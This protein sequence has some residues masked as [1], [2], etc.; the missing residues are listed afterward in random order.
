MFEGSRH[1]LWLEGM[2]YLIE[3]HLTKSWL[4]V[5]EHQ[6]F[7]L[8]GSAFSIK[9]IKQACEDESAKGVRKAA[10]IILAIENAVVTPLHSVLRQQFEQMA[11]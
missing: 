11:Q 7:D 3:K 5:I 2:G 8:F 10:R 4:A 6:S 9:Q 1:L